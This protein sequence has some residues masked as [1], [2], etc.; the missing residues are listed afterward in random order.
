[1]VEHLPG[2]PTRKK[3]KNIYNNENQPLKKTLVQ[4]AHFMTFFQNDVKQ[5]Y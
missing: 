5:I 2:S 4:M 3:N 1:M